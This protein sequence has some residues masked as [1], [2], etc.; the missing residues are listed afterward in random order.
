MNTKAK[1]WNEEFARFFEDPSREALREVLRRNVGEQNEL[2]FKEEWVEKSKLA[3]HV[4]AI[5]NSKGGCIVFGVDD[6][7]MEPRGLSEPKDKSDVFREVK[8]YLPGQLLEQLDVITFSY[9]ASEY[10]KLIGK[11]FQVLLISDDVERIPFAA[12][13]AGSDIRTAAIYVRR[14]AESLEAN[15]EELQRMINRRLETGVSSTAELDIRKHLSQLRVLYQEISPTRTKPNALMQS[16]GEMARGVLG[17]NSEPNPD[18]PAEGFDKFVAK[19]IEWKKQHIL[20]SLRAPDPGES[21][22]RLHS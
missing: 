7:T 17:V 9:E 3:K 6:G 12:A 16:L 11:T 15:Y 1:P 13:S 10:P 5:A 2:D 19:A 14:G 21:G 20:E 8:K 4:L 18:Y 22:S